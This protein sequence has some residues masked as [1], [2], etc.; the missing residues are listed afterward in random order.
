MLNPL[1]SLTAS[2]L[3]ML[4]SDVNECEDSNNGCDGQCNNTEGSY[5][6]QCTSGRVWSAENR[7]C[8]GIL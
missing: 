6:C 1:S 2:Y 3:G 7:T 5:D 8:E 4:D